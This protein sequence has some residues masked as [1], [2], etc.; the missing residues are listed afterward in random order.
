MTDTQTTTPRDVVRA[1]VRGGDLRHARRQL[2]Q[3]T[4]DDPRNVDA[5][6]WR[7]QLAASQREKIASL[8]RALRL[9]PNHPHARRLLHEALRRR[10]QDDP[11]LAYQRESDRLYFVRTAGDL[12]AAV[13]KRRA[14]PEPYPPDGA[15]PAAQAT[16]WL[17][18]AALGLLP[19]GLGTLVCAP[20]AIVAAARALRRPLTTKEQARSRLVLG[21][22][23]LLLTLSVALVFLFLLHF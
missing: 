23:S 18:W 7:A 4:R 16:R 20:L 17:G 1:A 11:F 3:M 12:N 19:A 13:P 2:R 15:S 8:S 9:A 21:A 5:W 6:L 14:V 22:A 10:F